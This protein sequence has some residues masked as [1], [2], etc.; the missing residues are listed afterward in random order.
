MLEL[1]DALSR[2][3]R[4]Q[5]DLRERLMS[6]PGEAPSTDGPDERPPHY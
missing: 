3:K 5:F 6:Q 4:Q 1:A 2:M